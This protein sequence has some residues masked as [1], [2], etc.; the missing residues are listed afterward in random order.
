MGPLII[1]ATTP[2]VAMARLVQDRPVLFWSCLGSLGL[3]G[4]HHL[5]FSISP[6]SSFIPS[7]VLACLPLWAL[8][9][10]LL[11]NPHQLWVFVSLLVTCFA[12]L[13]TGEFLLE[14]QRA[15]APLRDPGNYLTLLYL[16]GIPWVLSALKRDWSLWQNMLGAFLVWTFALAML[17]THMRFG[18]LVVI[19]ML[20]ALLLAVVLRFDVKKQ[21][22]LF[23]ATAIG[24]ALV[25]YAVL[26]LPGFNL[27]FC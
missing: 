1:V 8:T 26:D 12:L 4:C 22:V 27:V 10:A 15:H 24:L 14:Q 21:S 17:A 16:V 19:G 9:V 23:A 20:A 6:D 11:K 3:I 5:F 13:T 7:M 2:V 25:S 18:M